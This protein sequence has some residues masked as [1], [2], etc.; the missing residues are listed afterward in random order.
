MDPFTLA[1]ATFGVQKLRG[2]STRTAL[3]DAAL[4][5]GGSQLFGMTQAGQGLGLTPFGS[6]GIPATFEG[7]KSTTAGKG[8]TSLIGKPDVSR[9][10]AI[11]DLGEGATE[12]DIAT[13]IKESGEGFRGMST[14]GKVTTAATLLPFLQGEDEPVK[15]P[16][17]EE[18]YKREY[19]EQMAKLEGGFEPAQN[20]R[21]S[22]GEIYRS[23]MFYANQGG[24]AEIVK[25]YNHGG[26]NY[27][28]SKS[29][30]D[31]NDHNNYVR[32][33]GYVE[34]GAGNGDKDEDTM[35]AQLAD[36]EFVSRADAVLGAGILSGAD[37]KS[38]KSMRKAGADFFYDQ[39][40][41]FKRIYDLINASKTN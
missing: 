1:L 6:Q 40:K 18:D 28:P 35:L 13:Y 17:S 3:K 23:D 10:K 34:D 2:K 31:E 20:V 7:L 32:A 36:G 30:H 9:A 14:L 15:P 5:G 29:D 11:Q 16:F 26:I 27:L 8:I 21:P 4:V 19:E 12:A 38:F 25:K 22:M 33:Q 39:Q 37:P 24:L 41:K